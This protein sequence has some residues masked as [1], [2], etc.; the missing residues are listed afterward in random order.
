MRRSFD[1]NKKGQLF[2]ELY[3]Q[4][5]TEAEQQ[6][7][8]AFMDRITE[9]QAVKLLEMYDNLVPFDV[10]EQLASKGWKR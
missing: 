8:C 6:K 3:P 1:H 4:A 2:A 10:T 9:K 5:K 7:V